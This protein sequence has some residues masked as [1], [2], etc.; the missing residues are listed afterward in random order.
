MRT[1]IILIAFVFSLV[2]FDSFGQ[3]SDEGPV[4]VDDIQVD[5]KE[6]FLSA[7]GDTATVELYLISYERG[8]REFKLNSFASGIVDSKGQVYLYDVMQM[9][10]V[11]LQAKDR[12]NYLH[13][14]LEEDTPVKLVIQT[15][16]WKK[17]WGIPQQCKLVFEDS[18]EQGKFLEIIIDL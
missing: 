8:T 13:Y 5:V 4:L 10:K 2:T 12:Q 15:T 3:S 1:I 14:L 7:K 6:V 16:G 18:S 17:Q 11:R 9:G